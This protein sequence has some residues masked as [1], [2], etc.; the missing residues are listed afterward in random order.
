MLKL[1]LATLLS[2]SA[3]AVA[4]QRS[5][6][7]ASLPDDIVVSFLD[8]A[9]SERW[10]T[11][12]DNVM[13]GRS[14]GG[15]S[16]AEGLLTFSGSTNTD[17]GGFSSIRT[18]EREWD[19]GDADG[20]LMRVRGDGRTY[21]AA[22][23]TDVRLGRWDIS[24]W[25]RFETEPGQWRTVRLPFGSF[26]PTMFG[27][28]VSGRVRALEPED[29]ETVGL[30]IYDKQDGPFRLDV[31]WIGTYS[32]ELSLAG[33]SAPADSN[34]PASAEVR[35][36]SV[37]ELAIRR[38]VPRFNAGDAGACA[39]IYEVALTSLELFATDLGR[40]AADALSA[41]LERGRAARTHTDRAWAYREAMDRVIV[42]LSNRRT[43]ANSH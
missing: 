33:D 5:D 29:A 41:G 20:L 22:L 12:N 39:D 14:R 7:P 26:V 21:I 34:A 3:T 17:G 18:R 40:E 19:F 23:T 35:A 1:A 8:T 2:C 16:F 4:Q 25:Q 13:G 11:V 43:A 28:D 42:V 31:A 10:I 38:G 9:E 15:P 27:E 30:Y 6:P 37:L 24:Y 32:E 36:L